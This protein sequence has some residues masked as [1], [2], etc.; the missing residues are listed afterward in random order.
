MNQKTLLLFNPHQKKTKKKTP[1]Y[2][3]SETYP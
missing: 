1:R 2:K 3:Y